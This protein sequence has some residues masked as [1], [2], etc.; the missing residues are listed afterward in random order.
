MK[1]I[2]TSVVLFAA[3]LFAASAQQTQLTTGDTFTYT[4]ADGVEKTY[5]VVGEN[6]I[7]NPSFDEGTTGWTGGD[8]KALGSAKVEVSGGIDGG[9]FIIPTTNAGKGGNASIATA[10]SIEKGKTYVFS[11]YIRQNTNTSAAAKEGYI[12]TS[13]TD[14]P[15]GQNLAPKP[16][17]NGEETKTLM[18]AHED[19]DC[20]WTQN[21]VVTT[22]DYKYLQFCARWLDSRLGFDAFILA[23]VEEAADPAELETLIANCQEWINTFGDE[24]KELD[25]FQ[26]I[27]DKAQA[28]VE[29]EGITANELNAMV[30]QLSEALLDFR[31]ANANDEHTVDVTNRYLKNP[32]FDNGLTDWTRNN[33][34]VDGGSNIRFFEYFG[35][36]SRVLEINEGKTAVSKDTHVSQ[37]VYDLPLGYYRFTVQCVMNHTVDTTDP[38]AKS[39]AAIYCNGEEL[40]MVTEQIT[41]DGA[42][43]EDSYPQTFTIEGIVSADSIIV[44]FVGYQTNNFTYVAIDN[45]RL[46]YAGFD[47]GIYIDG[48]VNEALEWI[49]D[50]SDHLLPGIAYNLEE[51]AYAASGVIGEDEAIMNAAYVRLDSVFTAAK[52][53]VKLVEQLNK[54]YEEF[55]N[56][57]EETQYKGYD[58]AVAF[59]EELAA[60]LEFEDENAGYAEL[61]AMIAKLEQA[62]NDYRMSQDASKDAPADYTF[63]I[64]NANFE[65]KGNWVWNVTHNGGSTDCW[66][67]NCRP[68]MEGGEERRGVNLWGNHL[69]SLD[70]HQKLTGLPLG[71]YGISAEMITQGETADHGDYTTD[72]HLYVTGINTAVS[73]NLPAPGGWDAYQWTTLQTGYVVV[74]DGTLTIGA[75]SSTFGNA[76]EGWFQATNFKLQY[77]GEASPEDL[78]VAYEATLAEAQ[79]LIPT[80]IKGD[81][82]VLQ[83]KIDAAI[84]LSATNYGEAAALL[85]EP[86]TVAKAAAQTYNTYKTGAYQTAV[87]NNEGFGNAEAQDVLGAAIAFADAITNADTTTT[88]A[89]AVITEKLNAYSDYATYLEDVCYMVT[90]RSYAASNV[91]DVKATIAAQKADLTAKF[92]SKANVEDLKA[93]L[94]KVVSYMEKSA[95]LHAKAG[96]DV[97]GLIVNPTFDTDAAGWLVNKGTGNTETNASQHW[98]ADAANRYM[99]SYNGTKK[100]L[101]F[102]GSQ[103]LSNIPNGTYTV[104]VATRADSIGAYIFALGEAI[105]DTL[106]NDSTVMK[107]VAA[108]ANTKW[109]EIEFHADSLG[110]IWNAENDKWH[111]GS[112]DLDETIHGANNGKGF[113]W[114]WATIDDIVV[115]NHEMVIGVTT[116][117]LLT[118]KVFEGKWFSVDDWS[119]TLKA[120]GD[121]SNWT[122]ESGIDNVAAVATKTVYYAI[123]GRQIALPGKGVN[124]VKTVYS[125]GRIEVKKVFVK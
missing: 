117:S 105:T 57:V 114:T 70:L 48:L 3:G 84:A 68:I 31:M 95:Y 32:N 35:E 27:I 19:A 8:G 14:W 111:A 108:S 9:S 39:G 44:G 30:H 1:K 66:I 120:V 96:D 2:L 56:F 76:S 78:Q 58:E 46:E 94:Q 121:N 54:D 97:T 34:A 74:I 16:E 100:A 124:I 71:L 92:Q 90:D 123:D 61:N 89:L 17:L 104:K 24:A 13:E 53:S 52:Q 69:T 50:N 26:T 72:Q 91:N 113:G 119:L 38:E 67:G 11:Y 6:L 122:I 40:D 93:K 20:A 65:E 49:S 45:V 101:N 64:P 82:A 4:N 110:G 118:G 99:D 77:Y 60:F 81:A 29:S 41:T 98:G 51:E 75:T 79:A 116:D 28:L 23:E 106:V 18:Y 33:D 63:L 125:D 37:T 62:I 87:D 55:V 107:Q 10:W 103:V 80:L 47:A 115:T 73:E 36:S 22:A 59:I 43:K 7:T 85:V 25:A 12:V 86:I 83:A 42:A 112:E 102:H 15:Q 109:Q 5:T 21:I 88:A